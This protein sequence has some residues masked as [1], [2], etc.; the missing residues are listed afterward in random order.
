MLNTCL[1]E[2]NLMVAD[3][4]ANHYKKK[5]ALACEEALKQDEFDLDDVLDAYT[6][7]DV[8]DYIREVEGADA[9]LYKLS[10]RDII[11]YL[12]DTCS[13]D[14]ILEDFDCSD[15]VDYIKNCYDI[16]DVVTVDWR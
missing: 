13:L 7:R 1:L 14:D 3:Y 2:L 15:I 8:V 4:L 6:V 16:D 9:I 5:Y 10:D 11:S 12:S